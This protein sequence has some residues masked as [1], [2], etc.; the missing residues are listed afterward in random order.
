L[1]SVSSCIEA[2]ALAHS[3]LKRKALS[4]D[5]ETYFTSLDT[6]IDQVRPP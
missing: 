2:V 1:V 5:P 6:A 3:R 4:K